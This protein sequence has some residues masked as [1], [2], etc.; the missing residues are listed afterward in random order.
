ME[1]APTA[2]IRVGVTRPPLRPPGA[3]SAVPAREPTPQRSD[4]RPATAE[5][6]IQVGMLTMSALASILAALALAPASAL[7]VEAGSES[8]IPS[9]ARRLFNQ[10][11]SDVVDTCELRGE[12]RIRHVRFATQDTFGHREDRLELRTTTR[13]AAGARLE[14][15]VN[16]VVVF[17]QSPGED[18][19]PTPAGVALVSDPSPAGAERAA[20]LLSAFAAM[21]SRIF[22]AD[23]ASSGDECGATRGKPEEQAKCGAISLFGCASGNGLVCFI[24]GGATLLCLYAIEKAC[25][26]DPDSCQP[27]WTEG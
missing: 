17:A 8:A 4:A 15:M 22:A 21:H 24:S 12:T 26:Q 27:G 18:P 11:L 2:P 6:H 9:D 23:I 3:R 19:R 10:P 7:P 20:K 25:E 16:D 13:G 5:T 1:M 14:Y